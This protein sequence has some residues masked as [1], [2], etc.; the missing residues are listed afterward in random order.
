MNVN[1]VKELKRK[2]ETSLI[3]NIAKILSLSTD[4]I[5]AE[6][7][8]ERTIVNVQLNKQNIVTNFVFDWD[9]TEFIMHNSS[10]QIVTQGKMPIGVVANSA[11]ISLNTIHAIFDTII[12][13]LNSSTDEN[14]SEG[15]ADA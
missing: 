6:W 9:G 14:V 3:T 2:Y 13:V 8:L 4:A 15:E 11:A 5:T 10:Y 12:D 7:S 1:D